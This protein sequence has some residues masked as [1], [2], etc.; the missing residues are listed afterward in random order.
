MSV[1]SRA[2]FLWKRVGRSAALPSDISRTSFFQKRGKRKGPQDAK[3]AT[4]LERREARGEK[5]T[6]A[7]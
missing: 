1:M 3:L 4:D 7:E 2:S 5:M 6:G